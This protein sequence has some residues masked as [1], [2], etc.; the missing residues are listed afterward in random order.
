MGDEAEKM[1]GID[2]F[3]ALREA[4]RKCEKESLFEQVKRDL[5]QRNLKGWQQHQRVLTDD[6][7]MD[8]LQ[9]AYEESLDMTLYLKKELNK[10]ERQ[11]NRND[12]HEA[13][14]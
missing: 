12:S 8:S 11:R 2:Y 4:E 14:T 13:A 7:E 6:V 3:S 10:R 1:F 9:E 5:D